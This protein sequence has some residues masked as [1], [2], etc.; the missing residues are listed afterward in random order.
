MAVN[1]LTKQEKNY[2]GYFCQTKR[3]NQKQM[4]EQFGVSERTINRVLNELGI[5]TAVPRLKGEAYQVMKLLEKYHLNLTTLTMLLERKV[6]NAKQT[7]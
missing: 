6:G 5:A 7:A 1:C 3:A 2:I 4:A